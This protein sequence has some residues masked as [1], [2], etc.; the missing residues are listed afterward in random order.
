MQA[1]A[2][3]QAMVGDMNR[4]QQFAMTDALSKGNSGG[5]AAMNMASMQMGM[6]MGQQMINNMA[7]QQNHQTANAN[8]AAPAGGQPQAGTQFPKFCP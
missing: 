6:M 3:S 7:A 2:A 1:K 5:N 8:T 4:Y